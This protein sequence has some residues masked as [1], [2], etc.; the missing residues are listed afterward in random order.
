MRF[1]AYLVDKLGMSRE[2]EGAAG[3]DGSRMVFHR[4]ANEKKQKEAIKFN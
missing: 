1:Y 4:L 2:A 3:S